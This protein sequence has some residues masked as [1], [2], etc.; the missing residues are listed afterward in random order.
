MR[1]VMRRGVR[2][3]ALPEFALVIPLFLLMLFGVIQLGLVFGAQNALANGVREATRYASTVPVA[4]LSDAGD[5]SGGITLDVYNRLVTVL[6]QKLPGYIAANLGTCGTGA[7][8]SMVTYCRRADP[9]N[10]VSSQ[11][12]SIFVQVKGLYDAPLYFPVV[13]N[14]LGSTNGKLRIAQTEQMRV[15]T[16]SLSGSY[17]GGFTPCP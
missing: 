4:N 15:E 6:Q 8:N 11:S 9:N 3:Q 5:C 10:G 17:L 12:Y 14:L 16:F 1:T 2:G 13:G 7:A